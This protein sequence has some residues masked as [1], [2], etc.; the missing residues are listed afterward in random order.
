MVEN[1]GSNP[2]TF[3]IWTDVT[4]PNGNTYGPIINVSNFTM[5]AGASANRD[6]TQYV[7]ASA[8]SGSYF[9]N[10]YVGDYPDVVWEDDSFSFYKECDSDGGALVPNWENRG[11]SFGELTAEMTGVPEE[12]AFCSA[13]PNPFNPETNLTFNLP[14]SG[15]ISLKVFD[16]QG[17]EVAVLV[18]GWYPSGIY[19][20]PFNGSQLSSGTYI[21]F[22]TTDNVKQ[23]VKLL[24]IK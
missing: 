21:A 1:V 17:R 11:E 13:Y 23:S 14:A 7:P 12:C 15:K 22:L 18:D 9:Y 6:R 2:S 5:T 24:L 19:E 20:V 3:D 10:A 16:I 4:L 8:P